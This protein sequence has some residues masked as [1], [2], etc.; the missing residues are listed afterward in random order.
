MIEISK[1]CAKQCIEKWGK[2]SQIIKCISELNELGAVLSDYILY[3]DNLDWKN[4]D[5]KLL[6]KIRSEIADVLI[7]LN[8]LLLIFD[9]DKISNHVTIKLLRLITRLKDDAKCLT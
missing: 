1:E 4:K 8:S 5:K 6:C 7:T 3:K 2:D 9:E